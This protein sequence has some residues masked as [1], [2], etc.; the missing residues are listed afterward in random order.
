M[1]H[2][3]P[4]YPAAS[5]SRRHCATGWARLALMIPGLM[6]GGAGSTYAQAL[7]FNYARDVEQTSLSFQDDQRYSV[8][9]AARLPAREPPG[10]ATVRMG[11]FFSSWLFSQRAG[12]RYVRTKGQ[13][14]TAV[15]NRSSQAIGDG[16]EFPLISTLDLRNYLLI[17]R[18]ADLD[19]SLSARYAHYPLGTQD[20]EYDV[21]MAPEGVFGNISLGFDI[22]R[23]VRAVLYESFSYRTDFVDTRGVTDE[24]G[25]QRYEY[26]DNNVGLNADWQ[27]V[28]GK[29]ILAGISREDLIPVTREFK[30]LERITYR[31]F[32][33]YEQQVFL[34]N[35]VVGAR[36]SYDQTDFATTNR[37]DWNGAT[38][39]VY[40]GASGGGLAPVTDVSSLRVGAGYSTASTAETE[41]SVAPG[42]SRSDSF[43]M[44]G[45]VDLSTRLRRDLAHFVGFSRGV[46]S[47]F[48]SAFETY[49]TVYYRITW[50]RNETKLSAHT[51]WTQVQPSSDSVSGYSDW[52]IGLEGT[53]PLTEW[54][55]LFATSRYDVR[56][57]ETA[58]TDPAVPADQQGDYSTWANRLGTS[59]AVTRSIEFVTYYEHTIRR[60]DSPSQDSTWDIF[61]A[62]FIYRHQF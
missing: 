29:D 11:P 45:Y 30:D 12:Y 20:D 49:D 32:G 4:R 17:T 51:A 58:G 59:L 19:L 50:N 44:M 60:G 8:P 26:M 3:R 24:Y 27:L 61:E 40:L 14:L 21:T 33:A 1:I 10:S 37:S 22:T 41:P 7:R 2:L 62:F 52:S 34:P 38:Y 23:Y 28:K 53:L 16:S 57:N 35:M 42:G 47:G 43:S 31:E 54:I 55:S 25:G 13:P 5:R 48:E 18:N 9:Y 6:I 46:R 36:A 56:S 39:L 15:V